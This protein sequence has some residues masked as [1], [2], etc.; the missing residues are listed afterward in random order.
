MIEPT[1]FTG[2]FQNLL[3]L[4]S[5]V[6]TWRVRTFVRGMPWEVWLQGVS[7]ITELRF[8][9]RR[10][11]PHYGDGHFV[12]DLIED[13]GAQKVV[14]DATAPKEGE[15]INIDAAWVQEALD[16][17]EAYGDLTAKGQ[18]KGVIGRIIEWK[19]KIQGQPL[20][21]RGIADPESSEVSTEA[22]G[23]ALDEQP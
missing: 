5:R 21:A 8:T 4:A 16:H 10:P 12:H 15:G 6:Y 17:S 23:E 9:L 1:T 3:N 2:N 20:T 11:N 22:L 7:R 14:V 18:Q 19:K 13:V